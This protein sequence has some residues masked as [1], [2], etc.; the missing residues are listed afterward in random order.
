MGCFV[1]LV[2]STVAPPVP[3]LISNGDFSTGSLSPWSCKQATCQ[4]TDNALYITERTAVWSGPRQDIPVEGFTNNDDLKVAFKFQ[5]KSPEAIITKWKVKVTKSEETKYF[6]IHTADVDNQEWES[7][8]SNLTLPIFILGSDQVQL[9]LEVSPAE[10]DI[11]LDNISLKP[12]GNEK[13]DWEE[14]ANQRIDAIR[15]RNVKINFNLDAINPADVQIEIEQKN[16]KFPFGTAVKSTRIA[17][18]YD[19]N[20]DDLYCE[21]VRDNFN[22]L[23]DTYRYDNCT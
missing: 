23:V 2:S 5:I 8:F 10:A 1:G 20:E 18:C 12:E 15:K 4:V 6:T 17:E 9:Y 21:F 14:E 22:W 7:I 11:S 3:N 13:G 19:A 16:H